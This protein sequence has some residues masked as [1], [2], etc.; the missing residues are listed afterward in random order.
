MDRGKGKGKEK[1]RK[2]KGGKGSNFVDISIVIK[3][4]P[5]K[6][7]VCGAKLKKNQFVK[8]FTPWKISSSNQTLSGHYFRDEG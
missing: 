5:H 8:V 3:V 2:R 1:E 6:K 7:S 4:I